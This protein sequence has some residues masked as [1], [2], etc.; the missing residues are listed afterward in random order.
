[1]QNTDRIVGDLA[2]AFALSQVHAVNGLCDYIETIRGI[3]FARFGSDGEAGALG[4]IIVRHSAD[5]IIVF[6]PGLPIVLAGAVQRKFPAALTAGNAYYPKIHH[7]DLTQGQLLSVL[8]GHGDRIRDIAFS[9]DGSHAISCSDDETMRLW[10]L[11][12]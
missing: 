2:D 8:D 10:Q 1:M 6:L 3:S 5:D 4:L 7:W 11:P 12:R 9:P